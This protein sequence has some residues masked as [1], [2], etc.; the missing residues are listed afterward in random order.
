VINDD[1]RQMLRGLYE[2]HYGKRFLYRLAPTLHVSYRRFTLVS[3]S[4]RERI[5]IDFNLGF[6]TPMG[7]HA[8]VGDDF[9]IIETKTADGRGKSDLALKR[10]HVR[11]VEGCSKYCLGMVLTG[12][13]ARFNKFR[14]IV[15]RALSCM[16]AARRA[17]ADIASTDRQQA[18]SA[19]MASCVG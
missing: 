16:Q 15:R 7:R 9:I 18:K 19:W 6:E 11:S 2:K 10:Q 8:F 12:E 13:V 5:T 4:G 1:E 14:S 3:M 17:A